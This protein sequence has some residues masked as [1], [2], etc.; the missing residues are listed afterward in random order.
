MK[1]AEKG[2]ML[3]TGFSPRKEALTLYIMP[4]FERYDSIMNQLGKYR[5]D[6]SCLYIKKK[7]DVDIKVLKE[8]V[9]ETYDYMINK[10]G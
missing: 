1:A 3:K 5:T 9:I 2:D 10:Y 6:K 7:E 8:L 4:G